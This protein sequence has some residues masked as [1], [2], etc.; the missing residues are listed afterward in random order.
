MELSR[1]LGACGKPCRTDS[2]RN[3]EMEEFIS[4]DD[5]LQDLKDFCQMLTFFHRESQDLAPA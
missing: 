4:G 1:G 3:A 5:L 2:V